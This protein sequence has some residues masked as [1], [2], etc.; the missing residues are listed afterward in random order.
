MLAVAHE[1]LFQDTFI[2]FI[3]FYPFEMGKASP[4]FKAE[5]TKIKV[6]QQVSG[7]GTL[8]TK[9][10]RLLVLCS[11]GKWQHECQLAK[12]KNHPA[13]WHL[14]LLCS[15]HSQRLILA[16]RYCVCAAS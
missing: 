9:F 14:L 12:W 2:S 5:E 11:S 3:T 8:R 15:S 13:T 1:H 10:S 6:P 16:C 4:N 7:N